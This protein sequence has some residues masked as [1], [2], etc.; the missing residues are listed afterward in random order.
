[1]S[2]R[3]LEYIECVAQ[4]KSILRA[5]E[6]LYITPSALSKYVQKVEADYNVK[7]FDR[8]GKS[9]VLTYAGEEYIMWQK[10]IDT[11]Q[12]EM[13]MKLNDISHSYE[14]RIRL[15]VQLSGVDTFLYDIFPKFHQMYPHIFLEIYEGTSNSLREQ[16]EENLIDLAVLPDI[17]LGP[18]LT[19]T[20]L[21]KNQL[22]VVLPKNNELVSKAVDKE[23]FDYPWIDF[24]LLK[25][26]SFVAPF[27]GQDANRLF[28]KP[29]ADYGF[30]PNVVARM[31][32]FG[33]LLKCVSSGIGIT[34]TSDQIVKSNK[35][36]SESVLLSFGTAPSV[37]NLVIA[38]HKDHY[39][40]HCSSVMIEMFQNQYN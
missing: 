28:E 12:N 13:S 31:E 29:F 11:L 23:G 35:M 10:K 16:L 4:Y 26:E 25:S 2:D 20:F 1:M 33:S 30:E 32:N 38:S 19:S 39:L 21:A 18:S 27:S 5:S 40:D 17:G 22:V 14:G 6:K 15:G 7:L 8:V 9:F 24:T 3:R 36:N 34:I 37:N